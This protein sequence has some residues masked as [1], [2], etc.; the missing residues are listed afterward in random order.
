[1]RFVDTN[2]LLYAVG[3]SDADHAKA[4]TASLRQIC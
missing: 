4:E 1:M 2:V 3:T